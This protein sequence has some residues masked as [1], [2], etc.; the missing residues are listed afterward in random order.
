MKSSTENTDGDYKLLD[1]YIV[2]YL[3]NKE[4]YHIQRF[5]VK[6]GKNEHDH[7]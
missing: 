7:R 3:Y 6:K 4:K 2:V 1:N 5:S